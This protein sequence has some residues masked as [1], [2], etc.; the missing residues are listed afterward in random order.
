MATASAYGKQPH[1]ALIDALGADRIAAAVGASAKTV[2]NKRFEPSLPASW[3]DAIEKLCVDDG[4]PCPRA[5]FAWASPFDR[6]G[7]GRTR[8]VRSQKES[9]G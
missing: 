5:A 7:D 2:T 3:F 9:A 6:R 1:V 8:R 4:R